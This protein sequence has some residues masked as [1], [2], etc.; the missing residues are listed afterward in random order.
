MFLFAHEVPI[1]SW[2]WGDLHDIC[3]LIF[4]IFK[5][6]LNT[7]NIC[8]KYIAFLRRPVEGFFLH[9]SGEWGWGC[10]NLPEV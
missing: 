10:V 7:L 6:T 4:L 3:S 8:I 5:Y 1:A 9:E 2:W